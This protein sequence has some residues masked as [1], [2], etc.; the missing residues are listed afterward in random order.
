[1]IW[2]KQEN[3]EKTNTKRS[4]RGSARKLHSQTRVLLCIGCQSFS[5]SRWYR[6]ERSTGSAHLCERRLTATR[7]HG[8]LQVLGY[9][10]AGLLRKYVVEPAHMWWPATLVQVSLFRYVNVQTPI[11]HIFLSSNFFLRVIFLFLIFRINAPQ[12]IPK[13]TKLCS[14]PVTLFGWLFNTNK[15]L[16]SSA[17]TK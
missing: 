11:L 4:N 14:V 16:F 5:V 2:K 12:K 13:S 1:M 15:P 3:L 9:G 6:F 10:W 7:C 17:R 8:C